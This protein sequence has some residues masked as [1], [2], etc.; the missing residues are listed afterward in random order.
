M[1]DCWRRRGLLL[2]AGA[3]PNTK[4]GRYGVPALYAVTGARSVL[5]LARMLLDA[6]ANPTDGEVR[7]SCRPALS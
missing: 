2:D 3:D 6:G 4:D 7:V 1:P 5:P